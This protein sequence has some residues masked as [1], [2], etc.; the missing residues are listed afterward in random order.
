MLSFYKSVI[1][2]HTCRTMICII[3][4]IIERIRLYTIIAVPFRILTNFVE[5]LRC[6]AL[7]SCGR[8]YTKKI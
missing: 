1:Y 5:K 2:I 8:R 7:S 4:F 6:D 3:L